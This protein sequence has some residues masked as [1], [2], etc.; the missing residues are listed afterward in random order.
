[1]Q[2]LRTLLCAGSCALDQFPCMDYSCVPMA[3]RC[4]GSNDCKDGSDEANCGQ[5]QHQLLMFCS[6]CARNL[7]V[8]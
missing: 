5:L 3:S 4:D 6:F 1:M 2:V 8:C 7:L